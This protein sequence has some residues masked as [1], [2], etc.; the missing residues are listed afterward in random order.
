LIL[1]LEKV[2][3][4]EEALLG[5]DEQV[6]VP[7]PGG[8]MLRVTEALLLVTV[9]PPASWMATTGCVVKELLVTPLDGEVVKPS[10]VAGPTVIVTLALTALLSP[11]E[12][13]VSV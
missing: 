5:L 2:A 1:Q 13:T 8:V 9:L 3:T 12:A 7:P 6:R 11:P 10:L 4:P